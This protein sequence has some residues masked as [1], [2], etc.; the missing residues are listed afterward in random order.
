MRLICLYQ[1]VRCRTTAVL[2]ADF[3]PIYLNFLVMFLSKK[4]LGKASDCAVYLFFLSERSLPVPNGSTLFQD[5]S[6]MHARI[7]SN[8][9]LDWYLLYRSHVDWGATTW[10]R[11]RRFISIQKAF[12]EEIRI[13]VNCKTRGIGLDQTFWAGNAGELIRFARK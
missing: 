13:R 4:L 9:N 12:S 6:T 8:R 11:I 10:F 1:I 5:G 3:V 7:V 2:F